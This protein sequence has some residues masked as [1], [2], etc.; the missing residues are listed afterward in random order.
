MSPLPLCQL[1]LLVCPYYNLTCTCISISPA[2]R[3]NINRYSKTIYNK[4]RGSASLPRDK[5]VCSRCRALKTWVV[6]I[7]SLNQV[8]RPAE[9]V[10]PKI[11]FP[12]WCGSLLPIISVHKEN[13]NN[14]FKKYV[15]WFAI[16]IKALGN[17]IGTYYLVS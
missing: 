6:S 5:F 8:L 13:E 12:K 17:H 11:W 7:F 14:D 10:N 4:Y 1:I 9:I 2:C 3:N 16:P 15:T